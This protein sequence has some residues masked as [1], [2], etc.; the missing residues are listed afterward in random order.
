MSL[1]L[2]LTSHPQGNA[3]LKNCEAGLAEFLKRQNLI[4]GR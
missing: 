2:R 4:R 1:N 3:R